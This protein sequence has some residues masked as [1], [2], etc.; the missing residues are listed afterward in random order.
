MKL[1]SLLS[2]TDVSSPEIA[3]K[4][5][6]DLLVGLSSLFPG[7]N[8]RLSCS[9]ESTRLSI[10]TGFMLSSIASVVEGLYTS[11]L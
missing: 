3:L 2:I 10:T 11:R 6:Y 1:L 8:D 4:D 5:F 7:V 9:F